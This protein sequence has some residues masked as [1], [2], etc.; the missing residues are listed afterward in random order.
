MA[1]PGR[2]T[3]LSTNRRRSAGPGR[4]NVTSYAEG[5]AAAKLRRASPFSIDTPGVDLS[6]RLRAGQRALRIR[7]DRRD[8]LLDIMRAVSVSLEPEKVAELI[9]ERAATWVPAPCWAVVAEDAT[10]QL[11]VVAARGI[12]PA[13]PLQEVAAWVMHHGEEFLTANLRSDDR[14]KAEMVATV[15]GLP[16]ACRGRRIGAVIGLDPEPSSR[17]PRLAPTV[18]RAIRM[19]LEPAAVALDNAMQLK[20]AEALS[21]TD[22][23]TRLYNSRYLN[24]VLRR[25]TKRASR[26]GRPLSLLFIDLDGFKSI[27]DTHG[28]LFGSRALV[29]AATV[30]RGSARETDVVARFGGDEFALVLPDTGADG[31]YAVGERIRDRIADHIFLTGEGLTI[32]LTA[33]VGV[34]TL[35]DVAISADELVHAA[36]AAMYVVKARGKNGIQAATDPADNK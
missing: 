34:A 31:A 18:L 32:R 23:L 1:P 35:P 25:E 11:T 21:V 16:L 13:H 7:V 8:A 9:V 36:D 14:I 15:V 28:H 6:A 17:Q 24:Q 20:R 22:D 29:E 27:N 3:N 19:L 10:A 5:K 2:T 12:G 33:S 30:I 26:N 4:T